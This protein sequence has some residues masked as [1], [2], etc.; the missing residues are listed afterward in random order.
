MPTVKFCDIKSMLFTR[1][2]GAET[3]ETVN[4]PNESDDAEAEEDW[5]EGHDSESSTESINSH[6]FTLET[7]T[8]LQELDLSAYELSA[9]LSEE[10]ETKSRTAESC[11]SS[12]VVAED[13]DEGSFIVDDWR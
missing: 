11:K 10:A 4:D 1:P 6:T 3:H 13:D 8:A 2:I 12:T 5:L 7:D 9:L